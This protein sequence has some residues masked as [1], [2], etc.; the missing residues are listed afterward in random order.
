MCFSNKNKFLNIA[1]TNYLTEADMLSWIVFNSIFKLNMI[2]LSTGLFYTRQLFQENSYD[3][4]KE[5]NIGFFISFNTFKIK[6]LNI[7]KFGYTTPSFAILTQIN[8]NLT[9]A[10]SEGNQEPSYQT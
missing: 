2:F 5:E 3:L 6:F 8:W 7:T 10:N 4:V 9:P 1:F